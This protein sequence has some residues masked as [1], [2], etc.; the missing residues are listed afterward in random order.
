PLSVMANASVTA[1]DP[2]VISTPLEGVVRTFHVT[3]NQRVEAD[4]PLFSLDDVLLRS[5]HEAALKALEARRADFLRAKRKGFSRAESKAEAALLEK[6][7]A[8]DAA[9]VRYTREQLNRVTV[10]ASRAGVTIFDDPNDWLGRPVTVGEKVMLLADPGQV[11][12][13]A[14]VPVNDAVVLQQ[15]ARVQLFLNVRPT[16]PIPATL[17]RTA[18]EARPSPGEILAFRVRAAFA[19]EIAARPRIGLHGIAKIYGESVPLAYYLLRRPLAALRQWM[20]WVV[21]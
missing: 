14:W 8:L 10:R 4:T 19:P 20:G 3:P 11:E 16:D 12:I 15:G 1:R 2:L 13:E 9:E 18:F 7:M 17:I 6:R 21:F 5:R